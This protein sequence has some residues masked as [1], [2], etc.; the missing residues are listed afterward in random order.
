MGKKDVEWTNFT[1]DY[2]F[3]ARLIEQTKNDSECWIKPWNQ[4]AFASTCQIEILISTYND[5]ESSYFLIYC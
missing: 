4:C 1:Y 2:L 5:I 3:Y